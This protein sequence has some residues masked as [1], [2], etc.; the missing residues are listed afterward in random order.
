MLTAYTNRHEI[1]E[2]AHHYIVS[3]L[4]IVRDRNRE[5]CIIVTINDYGLRASQK[6]SSQQF[7]FL[8]CGTKKM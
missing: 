6:L 3:I 2:I 8:R 4:Y 5:S 1:Y 7:L